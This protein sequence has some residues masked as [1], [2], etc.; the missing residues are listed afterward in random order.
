MTEP[1]ITEW[2]PVDEEVVEQQRAEAINR[3]I[4]YMLTHS[5]NQQ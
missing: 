2:Q 4:A 1:T 3:M 5:L